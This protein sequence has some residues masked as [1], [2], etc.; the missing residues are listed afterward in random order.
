MELL[1]DHIVS[2]PV[3]LSQHSARPAGTGVAS[4]TQANT[5]IATSSRRAGNKDIARYLKWRDH[6][7][8]PHKCYH[9]GAI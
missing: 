4:L 6:W 3:H 8:A 5:I 9:C 2:A 1:R 7:N